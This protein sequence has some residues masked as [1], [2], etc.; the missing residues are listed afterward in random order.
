[1]KWFKQTHT[2][3]LIKTESPPVESPLGWAFCRWAIEITGSRFFGEPPS[4]R[5]VIQKGK[6]DSENRGLFHRYAPVCNG[7]KFVCYYIL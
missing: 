4:E 7:D 2:Q 5:G 1:M 6:H 3:L